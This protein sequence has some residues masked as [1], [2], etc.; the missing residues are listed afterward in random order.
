MK[1][2]LTFL[3]ICSIFLTGCSPR[4]ELKKQTFTYELGKD[5]YANPNM[6]IKN[7]EDYN[8][9]NV[10]VQPVSKGIYEYQNRFVNEG[11]GYLVCGEYKF[12]IVSGGTEIP[13]KIKVKDTQPPTLEKNPKKVTVSAGKNVNWQKAFDASDLSGVNYESNVDTSV[14]GTYPTTVRIFD[15]FGNGV[16]KNVNVVVQ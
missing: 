15:R 3:F 5:I 10:Q 12:K 11:K 7:A 16:K 4:Y 9:N 1:R 13:F 6:Y 8:L 14:M 2:I